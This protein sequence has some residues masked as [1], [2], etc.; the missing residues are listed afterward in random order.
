MFTQDSKS[1]T[2]GQ[3]CPTPDE[4]LNVFRE[5]LEQN[6]IPPAELA[7][8]ESLEARLARGALTYDD[9]LRELRKTL[10]GAGIGQRSIQIVK[11]LYQP[12]DVVEFRAVYDGGAV[13][14]CGDLYN[15]A[16]R[17]AILTAVFNSV[18]SPNILA[19]SS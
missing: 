7:A 17:T 14:L 12:G 9:A 4:I 5:A 8:L 19:S 10:V 6:I 11:Q 18:T 3:P 2:G 13:S 15:E 16:Q 1:A